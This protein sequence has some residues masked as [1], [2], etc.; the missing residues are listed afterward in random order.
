MIVTLLTDFGVQDSYVAEMKGVLLARAPET[1]LVDITHHVSLGDIRA[2]QYLLSRTWNQFPRG[3]VH[4][5]VVDPGVGTERRALAAESAGHR[6]LA[7]DN[8]LLSF[9]P[10]DARFFSLPVSRDAAPTFHGRDV[11][12]PA[13]ATL[14]LGEPIESLGSP[15]AHPVRTPLP[16]ARIASTGVSGEVIYVDRYGTLVS[17]VP[18]SAVKPGARIHVGGQDV[19]P[20]R[21]TFADGARGDVVAFSG[22]AGTVEVAVRDGSAAVKLNAGVGAH[23]RAEQRQ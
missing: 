23:V 15:V 11:F 6:F 1:Q 7:P 2:A 3:T 13:A 18:S 21:R 20:L 12:A 14:V 5:A 10:D 22:S 4:V 17:N 8:G 9:L 16:V 19:G